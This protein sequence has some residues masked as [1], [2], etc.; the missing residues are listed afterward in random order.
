MKNEEAQIV[1]AAAGYYTGGID[2]DIGP[3][4]L[5]AQQQ[6]E[7]EGGYAAHRMSAKRRL[8]AATQWCLNKLGFEA[9]TVDGY[10]GHNTRNAL[11]ALLYK[12]ATGKHEVIERR[13]VGQIVPVGATGRIPK[14]SEVRQ[15]YGDPG[16]QVPNRLTTIRLPFQLRIDWN[17]RQRTNKMTVHQAVA[18]G[19]EAA[20]IAVHKYYGE[21]EWRRLGLDRYAGGYNKRKMRGGSKWSMHAYGCAVDFYAAPNGL[22]ARCPQA[23][24]CGDEYRDFLDIMQE[25]EWLP[26]IRLWGADAMHFQRATL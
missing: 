6:I 21:D 20:M 23:L 11:D 16:N 8:V 3:K 17:L 25:H 15:V 24:F 9:G 5:K 13:D 2:G 1:W 7:R 18:P 4:S 26:A 19:L 10:A 22:R 12:L 14:Q